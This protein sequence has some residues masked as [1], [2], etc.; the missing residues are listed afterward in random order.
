MCAKLLLK[1]FK[2]FNGRG[3]FMYP[4]AGL[5]FCQLVLLNEDE[6]AT[7]EPFPAFLRGVARPFGRI[8][9][10]GL[11][12]VVGI[13]EV[14][15]AVHPHGNQSLVGLKGNAVGMH[16][17]EL[18]GDRAAGARGNEVADGL[19]RTELVEQEGFLNGLHNRI[20]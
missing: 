8:L 18:I 11:A 9:A 14:E 19:D 15:K 12:V 1:I 20:T 7:L 4:L 2:N 17:I 3:G 6:L 16:R 5:T 13:R 10:R